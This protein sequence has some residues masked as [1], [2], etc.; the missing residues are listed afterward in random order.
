MTQ[1]ERQRRNKVITY[2]QQGG[3]QSLIE[4]IYR[5]L[6]IEFDDEIYVTTDAQKRSVAEG[7]RQIAAGEGISEEKA[8]LEIEQWLRG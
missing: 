6:G 1:L 5:I 2:I 8:D 4:E 3:D 7:E